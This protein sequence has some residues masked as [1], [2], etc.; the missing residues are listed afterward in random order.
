[1][2]RE[3]NPPIDSDD[4]VKG[5][6]S[7]TFFLSVGLVASAILQLLVSIVLSHSLGS[8]GVGLVAL[9]VRYASVIGI[10]AM[11]GIPPVVTHLVAVNSEKEIRSS[12]L[13]TALVIVLVLSV[14][15]FVIL[16]LTANLLATIMGS[17][18][19]GPLIIIQ[20][21]GL[22]LTAVS[23]TA[24]S[25]LRGLLRFRGYALLQIV[26]P[27]ASLLTMIFF[28]NQRLLD[29]SLAIV[30]GLLGS[31]LAALLGFAMISASGWS[32]PKKTSIKSIVS[33]SFPLLI[34]GLSG[35]IIDSIDIII[36]KL[37]G[38]E[39]GLIGAYS[40]AFMLSIYLRYIVEP[41]ALVFLPMASGLL[42]RNKIK[43]T[44]I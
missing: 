32:S 24:S 35:T 9:V 15:A 4:N 43:E 8:H 44:Q 40:N 41:I 14:L 34:V 1:M 18:E 36:L 20:S 11:L 17:S 19:L 38:L 39:L 31:G 21:V 7:G 37:A 3:G 29:P 22:P 26:G 42:S 25:H 16:V 2:S 28:V 6:A 33:L 23:V 27:A 13:S 5:L 10:V 12:I 30:S